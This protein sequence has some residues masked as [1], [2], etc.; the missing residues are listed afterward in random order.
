MKYATYLRVSKF[1]DP[2][3]TG[4]RAFDPS[5]KDFTMA[6]NVRENLKKTNM[7]GYD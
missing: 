5:I 2:W 3:A 1:P 7:E 4:V 6:R